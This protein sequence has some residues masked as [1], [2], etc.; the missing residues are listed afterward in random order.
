MLGVIAG[1]IIGSIYEG[2]KNH[3]KTK[4]FPLFGDK[5]RFTDDTVLTMATIDKL[6][7]R[8]TYNEVYREYGRKYPDSGFG[9]MFINW[10][11]ADV[12]I[13][14]NSFGNGSAMRVCPIGCL[15]NHSSLVINEATESALATHNHPEGIRAAQ[16][17]AMCI[18]LARNEFSKDEIKFYVE[19]MFDYD[20]SFS[21]DELRPKYFHDV[22]AEGTVPVVI[23]IFL[24]STDFEDAI[25]LAISMGGDS[26]TN[27]AIV[28]GIAEAFYGSVPDYIKIEVIKYL[29]S[30][31]IVLLNKFYS[32]GV[33]TNTII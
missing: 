24:D 28:G 29:P 11:K 33:T 31:F 16:C 30:D 32:T 20:L 6:L 19:E 27:A 7:N 23:R 14:Y 10:F 8:K 5:N 18:F 3:I 9:G 4:D 2:N 12:Q 13:P 1:D 21:L 15:F 26:D 17:I 25:R 22:T